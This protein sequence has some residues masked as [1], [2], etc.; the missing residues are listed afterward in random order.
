MVSALVA[1]RS[2]GDEIAY[3]L[4]FAALWVVVAALVEHIFKA[5][6][7]DFIFSQD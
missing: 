2:V 4:M 5:F 6:G 3:V 7:I 1:V